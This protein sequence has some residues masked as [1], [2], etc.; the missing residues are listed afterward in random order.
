MSIE[1]KYVSMFC[2]MEVVRIAKCYVQL[3]S[4]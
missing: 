3:T 4:I 1:A 2:P